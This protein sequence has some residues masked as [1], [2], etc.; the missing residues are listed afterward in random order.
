MNL[1]DFDYVLP[2]ELIAQEGPDDRE[3]ARLMVLR[4][5]GSRAHSG[6]RQLADQFQPGDLLIVNNTRVVRSR[7]IG[8]KESGGK[9]DCLVLPLVNGEAHSG[10]PVRKALLRG[11]NIQE[12]TV[13]TF[14]TREPGSGAPL[15]AR[16]VQKLQGAQFSIQ[17]D[18]PGRIAECGELP[19]PP[20]IKKR[21]D[22]QERYQTVYSAPEGSLAAPTAGLHFTPRLLDALQAKG[23]ER[24]ELTLHV[25]IGTFA[26]I[27]TDVVENWTMHPEYYEV[28]PDAAERINAA[29]AAGRRC[30]AVG[31]TSV[32]TLESVTRDGQVRAGSGWTDIYIYPGYRF[33]FPYAGLMT[34][35][36]L[37]KSTLLLL[38]SAFAGKERLLEAYDEA[39]RER[40]RFFSLGDA[41]L[42]FK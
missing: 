1:S 42:I 2:K 3:A 11:S 24:A 39:V 5:D 29:I 17:F 18:E 9:V 23:V 16:V 15:R 41:M 36:H 13:L 33:Q 4:S 35:F 21:L 7:L 19:L 30:F 12:G 34:N 27:R 26:P 6:I 20:Y 38:A 25:G 22:E 14:P 10:S 31:T 8:R 37:P 28:S 32:R 40:Y